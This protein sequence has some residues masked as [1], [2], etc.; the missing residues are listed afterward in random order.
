MSAKKI[1]QKKGQKMKRCWIFLCVSILVLAVSSTAFA[2]WSEI[3]TA[4]LKAKM[5]G[6]DI[7]VINPLSLIEYN[8]LHIKG[9]VNISNPEF[10]TKLPADKSAPLAFYCLGRK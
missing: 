9:S 3:S 4:D 1:N 7:L 5:D 6:G 8:N 10:K 2:K